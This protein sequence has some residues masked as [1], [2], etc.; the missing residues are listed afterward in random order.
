LNL[1]HVDKFGVGTVVV[2]E[3]EGW[4]ELERTRMAQ[5]V[6]A[7][8]SGSS[9]YVMHPSGGSISIVGD[10][11]KGTMSVLEWVRYYNLQTAKTF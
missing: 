5:F 11:G 10:E 9:N 1:L 2:E 7:W 6:A 3:G 4:T 8:R